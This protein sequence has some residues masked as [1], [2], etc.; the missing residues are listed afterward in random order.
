MP[1]RR[2]CRRTAAPFNADGIGHG[3][4]MVSVLMLLFVCF[5]GSIFCMLRQPMRSV[6]PT[7]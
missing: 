2:E 3:N 1:V 6:M 4:C 5:L 7:E